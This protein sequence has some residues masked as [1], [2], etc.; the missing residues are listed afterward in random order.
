MKPTLSGRVTMDGTTIQ[1][2]RIGEA[3]VILVAINY[4][5]TFY[6]KLFGII[7]EYVL[8]II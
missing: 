6:N 5:R 1:L 2:T 8:Y 3:Q 4:T 7:A